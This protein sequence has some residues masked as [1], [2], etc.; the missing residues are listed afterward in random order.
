MKALERQHLR[1]HHLLLEGEGVVQGDVAGGPP[2]AQEAAVELHHR[3]PLR[4]LR[5]RHHHVLVYVVVE[6]LVQVPP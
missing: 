1:D 4:G 5:L 6:D 3:G 2:E